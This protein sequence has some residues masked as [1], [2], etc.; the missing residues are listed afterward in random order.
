MVEIFQAE[1]SWT[2]S[3][4]TASLASRAFVSAEGWFRDFRIA[5]IGQYDLVASL[6]LG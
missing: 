6:R 5:A 1:A 3:R 4:L 2:R